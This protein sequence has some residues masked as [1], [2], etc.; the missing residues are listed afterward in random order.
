MH[1]PPHTLLQGRYRVVALIAQGGM[2]AVYQATDERLGNTVALKQTLMSDPQLRAAFEREARLLAGL[3]HPALPVVSDHFSEAGG[4]FL[5][6]Q[7][8]PGD[9]LAALLRQHGGP[10]PLAEVRPW[11]DRLL[12]ALDYLHTRRPPIIHRDVKPQNLKLTARGEL[13]LLDFGLAKGEPAGATA[14]SPSLFGYTPQYAPL[15]QIQGSGTDARSDL[16]S[17]AATLYELLTGTIP[18][19]ALTRAAASVRGDVDP[20]RPAHA[21]NPQLPPALSAL[22]AQAL[23]LNPAMRPL[24]AAAMRAALNGTPQAQ[25]CTKPATAPQPTPS[26]AG[27]TTVAVRS[28]PAQLV[29]GSS[30]D[31][32]PV[33]RRGSSPVLNPLLVTMIIIVLLAFAFVAATWGVFQPQ[34]VNQGGDGIV[35]TIGGNVSRPTPIAGAEQPTALANPSGAVGSTRAQPL[36]PGTIVDIPGWQVELL[37]QLRGAEANARVARAN[38]NNALPTKSTEYVLLR[39][40][41]TST[42]S[43]EQFAFSQSDVSLVGSRDTVYR[44]YGAVAPSPRLNSSE[45]VVPGGSV[46]GWAAYMVGTDE[47]ALVVIFG[48]LLGG[49]ARM[50]SLTPG[51]RLDPDSESPG[52]A[53]NNVGASSREPA[54]IG[55][56]A[57]TE[58]WEIGLTELVVGDAAWQRILENY[59]GSDPPAE[60]TQYVLAHV[61]ARYLGAGDEPQLIAD[62]FFVGLGGELEIDQPVVLVPDNELFGILYPGGSTEGWVVLSVPNDDTALIAFRGVGISTGKRDGWRYFAVN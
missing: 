28:V 20:L 32:V 19:D 26:S 14:A 62:S 50:L 52:V 15:E 8:I 36:P 10:F 34:R 43:K 61:F 29:T 37:E 9:D 38:P 41:A 4:Q 42:V 1:L 35:P 5:V 13:I 33:Q 51:A 30:G 60:G 25:A 49:G 55:E 58:D 48:D 53:P 56:T 44:G 39:V 2:G 23:T 31:P 21:L 6:M 17:V 45:Q 59:S 18:P 54:G 27:K 24:S 16:Y 7:F 12:D 40:R 57:I 46:E 11:A 47:E 3:Q 22:L